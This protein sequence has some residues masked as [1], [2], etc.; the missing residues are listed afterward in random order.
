MAVCLYFTL[1]QSIILTAPNFTIQ[2]LILRPMKYNPTVTFRNIATVKYPFLKAFL[3]WRLPRL[4]TQAVS[5]LCG[6]YFLLLIAIYPWGLITFLYGYGLFV[7]VLFYYV[8]SK[9]GMYEQDVGTHQIVQLKEYMEYL[10]D[11]DNSDYPYRVDIFDYVNFHVFEEQLAEAGIID[12]DFK[13]FEE[14]APMNE[15]FVHAA[16]CF[17]SEDDAVMFKLGM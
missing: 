6:S 15:A 17:K 1:E 8:F 10:Y 12:Y 11:L 9:L 5:I 3:E 7:N 13:W 16:F 2:P 4:L 14:D